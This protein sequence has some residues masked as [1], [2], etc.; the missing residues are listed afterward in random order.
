MTE[1]NEPWAAPEADAPLCATVSVPGSK[2]L[3]NRELVLSALAEKPSTLRAALISRDSQLMIA[4][5]RQLGTG[6]QYAIDGRKFQEATGAIRAG[7][8]GN[9]DLRL[10]PSAQ[11]RGNTHIQCGLAG[12]VMRFM[13]AVAAL[14]QG[15][16]SF[17]GDEYARQ[18]PMRPVLQA[19][20]ELGVAV[21]A[22]PGDKMPF[23]VHGT[24]KVRGGRVEIDASAS[25]Q[26][27]SGLLLAAPRFAEGI[28]IIHTGD[29]LP[30]Q[31]HIEMTLQV[32]KQR[33][34]EAEAIAP[35]QWRVKPGPIAA[36]E[37][38]IEPDLSNAA[39]FLAAALV[40]GGSVTVKNWPAK[41]TQVGD[42]LRQI[43]PLFGA[44]ISQKNDLLTVRGT[45]K[46]KGVK[47]HLPEAGELAPTLIGLAALAETSSEITG[48]GHIRHHETD[49][50]AALATE[51]NRL[52]GR[53]RELPDGIALTPA[54]LHGE[55]WRCY[56]DHR[57]ATTAALIG[58]RVPGVKIDDIACTT[59]TLPDFPAMWAAMLEK[60]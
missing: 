33:G 12:T 31:P 51:I 57:M 5:L 26:F 44:E 39:P 48:I 8:D 59:K 21:T 43:L 24:G 47:L 23:T 52:G 50:I 41:T 2:S 17:D 16:V 42:Q 40:S 35:G 3:T 45:G 10:V 38:T 54:P 34:V 49:R 14:A 36:A 58:L 53:A 32:L 19:L 55:T 20:R 6:I 7:S 13:P 9:A 29:I 22:A 15:E 11:M 30:S 46:I 28:H 25:S 4:A 37:A 18:R 60:K 27:V 1:Q 56:A